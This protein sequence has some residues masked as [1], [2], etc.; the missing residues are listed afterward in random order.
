VVRVAPSDCA[1]SRDSGL[2]N[3][4]TTKGN[5]MENDY[6][7]RDDLM[8]HHAAGAAEAAWEEAAYDVA[9]EVDPTWEMELESR[10]WHCP[11]D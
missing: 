3:D 2:Y 5:K 9:D 7:D 6:D 11:F 1:V 4:S 8:G 10:P